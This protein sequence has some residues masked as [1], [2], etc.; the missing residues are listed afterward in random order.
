MIKEIN[1]TIALP[2]RIYLEEKVASVVVPALKAAVNIL[3][4]RA[5]SVFVLDY[6]A[7]DIL[8]DAGK[9]QKRYFVMAGVAEVAEN[10]CKLMVQGIVPFEDVDAKKAQTLA[11]EAQNEQDRLF[12]QMINNFYHGVSKRYLQNMEI[13]SES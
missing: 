12:Y 6:G 8:D 9:L 13:G 1:L 10:N 7:L 11:E 5:P 2:G 4:N 3:P